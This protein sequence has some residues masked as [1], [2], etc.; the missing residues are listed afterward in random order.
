MKN[1][2]SFMNQLKPYKK[3]ILLFMGCVSVVIGIGAT[4]CF[5]V[6]NIIENVSSSVV[7]NQLNL[8]ASILGVIS[9]FTSL[10]TA[11]L[12]CSFWR[13]VGSLHLV[14][15][16]AGRRT[17]TVRRIGEERRIGKERRI[18]GERRIGEDRRI[19]GERRIRTQR[20]G[21]RR[22]EECSPA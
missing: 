7:I 15:K 18:E 13:P 4:I 17:G 2:N 11:A 10:L 12:C 5:Y 21:A 19:G 3:G 8:M 9:G 16:L 22:S 20:A 1:H 6:S 14:S